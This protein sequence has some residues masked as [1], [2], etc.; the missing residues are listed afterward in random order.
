MLTMGLLSG[1]W[2]APGS[3]CESKLVLGC[4]F[5]GSEEDGCWGPDELQYLLEVKMEVLLELRFF[6]SR[7]ESER[8]EDIVFFGAKAKDHI[9]DHQTEKS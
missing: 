8:E 1:R 2:T 4:V 7:L 5:L 9:L 3:L 6:L